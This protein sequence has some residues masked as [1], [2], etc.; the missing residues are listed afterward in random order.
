MNNTASSKRIETLMQEKRVIEPPRSFLEKSHISSEAEY[1]KLYQSSIENPVEFWKNQA[2]ENLIWF[3]KPD[4]VLDYDWKSIGTREG[5]YTSFFKGGRLNASV[6]CIDRHIAEGKGE[7]NAIIWQGEKEEESRTLTYNELH[8]EVC[9]LS[10]ILS[11]LGIKK[12]DTVTIYLPMIPEMP[13]SLLACARI[14][15]IHSVVFSAFSAEALASRIQDCSSKLVI[16]ADAGFHA[17]KTIPLKVNV[18][19]ALEEC[20][21]V[22]NVLV[23]NRANTNIRLVPDRDHL[24]H[25]MAKNSDTDFEPA[26]MDSEDPLFILYT[27]GSTGKPKGVLHTTAGYLLYTN[28]TAK[29]FFDLKD[30]DIFWCTADVG[31]ITGHSYLVYG[32]LSNGASCVMFEG[33]P[34][35]PT[36]RRFW[37]IIE[38]F[39]VSIFY[40]APTAIRALMRLGEEHP[41]AHDLS[42][43]RL[44]GSVGEPIN[45]E[46][47]MWYYS[48]IGKEKCPVIDTWWQTETG[49]IMISTLPGVHSMKPGAAGKPFFGI[50]PKVLAPDG[51]EAAVNEGGSLVINFPWPG[52]LRGVYGD[53]TNELI[54]NVYFSAFPENYFSSDG[55]RKDE[56]GYYWL[57]GRMDDV[58]NVSA[59]RLATAEIES[60]LVSYN[61][62]SEAAVVGIP[63]EVKGQGIYCY[64]SLKVGTD[65]T[66]ELAKNLISHVRT[67]I[68]PIASPDYIHFTS[69]LPKTRSGKIMRRILRKIAEGFD[70]DLGDIST[71]ADPG[72][73]SQLRE[74]RPH[75]ASEINKKI[76][77]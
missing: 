45:P 24:W 51:S 59:H 8:D 65:P 54:N 46:A 12:G 4:S 73:V 25:E 66:I 69:N 22:K 58:I 68:S 20:S 56:D 63:H 16:T 60:A 72:V 7:K 11:S 52:M 75:S 15:A 76:N 31:W 36:P 43:L 10:N 35:Y 32:P 38:K 28:L 30:S 2:N 67:E 57:L 71:L 18:D 53:R 3:K 29:Y 21:S 61:C 74:E 40:T 64:V 70:G 42:S 6:Q 14:G 62:V 48:V 1:E 19:K 47:W 34:T 27:S 39:K 13:I 44:L 23:F 77:T 5:A 50:Q 9:K 55:A 41:Q 26:Q 49:G 17:G 37:E 33:V